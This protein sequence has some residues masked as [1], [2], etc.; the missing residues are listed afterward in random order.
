MIMKVLIFGN[1]ISSQLGCI[2]NCEYINIIDLQ[3]LT[4][5]SKRS[6]RNFNEIYRFI[7][8]AITEIVITPEVNLF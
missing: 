6:S 4:F 8:K 2:L 5:R 3:I 1:E 7:I